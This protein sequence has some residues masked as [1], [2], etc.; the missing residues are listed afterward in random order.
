MRPPSRIETRRI[1]ASDTQAIVVTVAAIAAGKLVVFPTDTLYG[2]GAHAFNEE[3]I[4][5]LYAAKERP[6]DKGIPILL[7]D[8]DDIYKVASAIPEPARKLMDKFWPGPL[9][10]IV[11][12]H[13]RLPKSISANENVAVRIPDCDVARQVIRL[14][15]GAV[16]TSSANRSGNKPA[17][18]A[19]EALAELDGTVA[20]VLDDGPTGKSLPS[21]IIDCTSTK[22]RVLRQGPIARKDLLLIDAGIEWANS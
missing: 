4:L 19:A 21:T 10:I 5:R 7:A 14:S 22:L 11:P 8:V 17:Q 16:A 12:K 6:N 3:A 9:T 18:T 2:V 13:E 15:G 1:L 20:I